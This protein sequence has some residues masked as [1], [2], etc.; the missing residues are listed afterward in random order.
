MSDEAVAGLRARDEERLRA[1]REWLDA[2]DHHLLTWDD[3]RFPP[4]LKD[5][6]SPPAALWLDGDPDVLWQPQLAVIGS[7]NP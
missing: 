7:R 6:P 2:A 3:E 5:I 1:D 4:L